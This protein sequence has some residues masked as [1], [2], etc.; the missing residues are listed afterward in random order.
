M[1]GRTQIIKTKNHN[2]DFKLLA[3]ADV[4]KFENIRHSFTTKC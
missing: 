1:Y 3:V 4:W 2:L